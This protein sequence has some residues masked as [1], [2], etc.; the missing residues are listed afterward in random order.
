VTDLDD[1]VAIAS[2]DP[3]DA[4]GVV[5]R[6]SVQW[7]EAIT[8]ARATDELPIR[9][10]INSIVYCG[11][12]G[13]GIAGNVLAALAEESGIVPVTVVKGYHLPAYAGANS[14]VVCASYS[15][16]T[17]ETLSCFEE[18]VERRA[19][20]V[21]FTTGG[22]LGARAAE[23]GIPR[24]APVEGL[25]PRAAFASL[26]VPTIVVAERLGLL[27]DVSADLAECESVI[28]GRVAALGRT[29]VSV[30][31]EAKIL[32]QQLFGK[33][34]LIWGQHGMLSVAA[35]RWRCQLNENAKV[36]AFSNELSELDHNEIEG[37]DA[38][39]PLLGETALIVLRMPG[40]HP[41]VARRVDAT[42]EDI[43][44]KVGLC[45]EAWA[46]G[47]SSLAKLMSAVIL[48]DFV[49][50]YLAIRRGVDPT[51]VAMIEGLKRRIA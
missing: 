25:Q 51:S 24:I 37:F 22:A 1:T 45:T 31:N 12:G 18:A 43:R 19:R 50:V 21:A 3:S 35:A 2:A 33:L 30:D 46:V 29:V 28:A 26:V 34:P 9:H 8:R 4:L 17:E 49:S 7:A 11:M 6:T 27:P 32:A 5:E 42:L 41:R 38:R 14:L 48:G 47:S 20:V 40:E 16:N 39:A 10:G 13:S 15:G 23:L 44:S 36:L